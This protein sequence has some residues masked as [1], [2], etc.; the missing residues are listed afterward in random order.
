[1]PL[2]K[3]SRKIV[4]RLLIGLGTAGVVVFLIAAGGLFFPEE[5]KT[6]A[7]PLHRPE[8]VDYKTY[9]AAKGTVANT[10]A[11]EGY[12]FPEKQVD[13]AFSR[14]EGFLK[15]VSVKFGQYVRAGQELASLDTDTLADEIERQ[16]IVLE[17]AKEKQTGLKAASVPDIAASRLRLEELRSDLAAARQ[18]ND[19][20]SQ[21]DLRKMENEVKKQDYALQKLEIDYDYRI[22]TAAREIELAQNKLKELQRDME[23]SILLA[24]I[25]G[26]VVYLASL[27]QG[28]HVPPYK[29]MVSLADPRRLI[30]RYVGVNYDKFRLGMKVKVTRQGRSAGGE[31]V[32]TPQQAPEE[33]YQ[34]L[35]QTIYVRVNGDL[36]PVAIDDTATIEAVI[37]KAEGVIV[38]PRRLVHAYGGHSFVKVL[39][40]GVVS[41]RDVTTG[42][43][44]LL[45]VE[46]KAGLAAGELVVE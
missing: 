17:E 30:V 25:A 2:V 10:V 13:V 20:L 5:E 26:R 3:L 19:S 18:V 15:S 1:M 37:E 40:D 9:T 12:F 11:C 39:E 6:L 46:I 8:A 42:V 31:V 24:P 43:E 33:D 22:K 38:L 23:K 45:E 16:A 32:F 7:P 34:K 4:V 29:I 21:S 35:Q 27:S 36:G 28:E 41:E 14:R 44:S